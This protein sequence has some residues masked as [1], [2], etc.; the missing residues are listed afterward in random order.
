MYKKPVYTILACLLVFSLFLSA[1]GQNQNDKQHAN[2]SA[3]TTEGKEEGRADPFGKYDP[4]INLEAVRYIGEEVKFPPGQDINN[5]NWATLYKEMGINVTYKWIVTGKSQYDSKLNLAIAANDLPDFME[6]N[7]TQLKQLADA[8]LLEDLTEAFEKYASDDLKKVMQIEPNALKSATFDGKLLAIPSTQPV[9]GGS[10]PL[11]WLRTDWMQKLNLQP[12]KTI[13]DVI[14]IAEAFVKNDPDGNG[15][16]D[17]YGI[18]LTK[19][20]VSHTSGIGFFN[21]YNAFPRIWIIG[22][23]GKLEYG[24]IQPEMKNALAKLQELYQ[25]KLIDPEFGVKDGVKMF[26]SIAANKIGVVFGASWYP[27]WPFWGMKEKDPGIEWD[28]YPVPSQNGEPA[29]VQMPF[30]VSHY[31][32]LKK[33]YKHPEVIVKFANLYYEKLYSKNAEFEKYGSMLL[34]NVEYGLNKFSLVEV[35]NPNKD[36]IRQQELEKALQTGSDAEITSAETK[37]MFKEFQKYLAGNYPLGWA[38]YKANGPEGAMKQLRILNEQGKVI[39]NAFVGA[40][41]ETMAEKKATLDKLE[42]ETFVKIIMGEEPIDAFDKFVEDWKKL[43]GDQI[44]TEVNE[45]YA[46]K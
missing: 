27:A 30:A 43:G 31:Y 41:T 18:A 35:V 42:D 29:T 17:T 4:P 8:D 34:D 19:D 28:S 6:V 14:R 46:S 15:K 37:S 39:S 40:S 13:D 36:L 26:E 24:S 16:A 32:V 45:W 25:A 10:A 21:A 5:N 23:S 38:G 33:G 11:L 9:I 2:S 20:L 22:E 1:C 44:T 7:A 12:P 3:Q